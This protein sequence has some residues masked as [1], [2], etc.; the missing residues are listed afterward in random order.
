MLSIDGKTSRFF[1][2]WAIVAKIRLTKSKK[3]IEEIA[4]KKKLSVKCPLYSIITGVAINTAAITNENAVCI[5]L[6]C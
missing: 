4:T 5:W 6:A 3:E 2:F 1:R